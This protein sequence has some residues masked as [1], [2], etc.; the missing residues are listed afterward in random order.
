MVVQGTPESIEQLRTLIASLDKPQTKVTM[1]VQL[2]EMSEARARVF[3]PRKGD[4]FYNENHKHTKSH[5]AHIRRHLASLMERKEARV[6]GAAKF[7]T[8]SFLPT[9]VEGPISANDVDVTKILKKPGPDFNL[10]ITATINRDDSITL[11]VSSP[12]PNAGSEAPHSLVLPYPRLMWSLMSGDTLSVL[13]A[14]PVPTIG[15]AG[16]VDDNKLVTVILISPTLQTPV[17]A[18]EGKN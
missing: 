15:D 8:C 17:T 13:L 11:D 10:R 1:E 4:F 14:E 18:A 16:K 5:G 2:V 3:L 7:D 12:A 9:F 6:V